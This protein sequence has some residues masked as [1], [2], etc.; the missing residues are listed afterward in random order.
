LPAATPKTENLLGD[1]GACRRSAVMLAFWL[2][3]KKRMLKAKSRIMTKFAV[4]NLEDEVVRRAAL[5]AWIPSSVRELV[6]RLSA[7]LRMR[8]RSP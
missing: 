6:P 8:F 7:M 4:R 2:N 5:F 1:Q 3:A